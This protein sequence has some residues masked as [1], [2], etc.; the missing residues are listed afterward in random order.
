MF[1][2]N[3]GKTP[4]SLTQADYTALGAA[5]A[6]FSGS[7]IS[8][9]VRE[10]LMEPLRHCRTAKFFKKNER[11][12]YAPVTRDPSCER[13]VPDLPSLGKPA[14]RHVPCPYCGAERMSLYDLSGDQLHVPEVCRVSEAARTTCWR[15]VGG[16]MPGCGGWHSEDRFAPAAG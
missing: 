11:G 14:P 12:Q 13:C 3:L 9:V 8:V 10:A 7:D 1:E 2:L 6:G 16:G 4:H 15:V 5:A